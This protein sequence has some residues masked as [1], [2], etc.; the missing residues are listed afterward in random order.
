VDRLLL[1]LSTWWGNLTSRLGA[2]PKALPP[3]QARPLLGSERAR[4]LADAAAKAA[5]ELKTSAR[6]SLQVVQEL[7]SAPSKSGRTPAPKPAAPWQP[8]AH[9]QQKQP[10][11]PAA[12]PEPEHARPRQFP[13]PVQPAV[14]KAVEAESAKA[15]PTT[16]QRR[17]KPSGADSFG[18]AQVQKVCSSVAGFAKAMRARIGVAATAVLPSTVITSAKVGSPGL[19]RL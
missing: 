16:M 11:P 8:P 15:G 1:S 17:A 13:K 19:S 4:A 6:R 3:Q 5:A 14:N 10:V 9:Q 18:S 2:G 7:S 12:A